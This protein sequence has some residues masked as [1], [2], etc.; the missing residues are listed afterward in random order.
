MSVPDEKLDVRGIACPANSAKIL[1][2]IATMMSGELLEVWLDAG[3]PMANV[4]PVLTE[5]GHQ[6]L[7]QR[8]LDER[9]HALLVRVS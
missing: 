4:P 5:E 2:R 1:I 7:E 8:K 3:E 6:I 9:S